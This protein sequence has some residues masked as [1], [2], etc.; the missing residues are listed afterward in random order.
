MSRLPSRD[1]KALDALRRK[2]IRET[3]LFLS[4]HLRQTDPSHVASD[5]DLIPAIDRNP[6]S[7]E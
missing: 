6:L 5:N 3:E 4:R 1:G 2:M 7:N